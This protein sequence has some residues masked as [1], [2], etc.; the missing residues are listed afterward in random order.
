[1][2]IL[3]AKV[4]QYELR[5]RTTHAPAATHSERL[6]AGHAVLMAMEQ[7]ELTRLRKALAHAHDEKISPFRRFL[8]RLSEPL[9][10]AIQKKP[11][12]QRAEIPEKKKDAA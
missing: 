1:M 7:D 2:T 3:K 8:S 10:K 5:E 12:L 6:V 4:I 9:R 11:I